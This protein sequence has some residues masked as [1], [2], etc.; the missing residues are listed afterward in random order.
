MHIKDKYI[1]VD[2]K[3]QELVEIIIQRLFNL[4]KTTDLK[5]SVLSVISF[6]GNTNF[7]KNGIFDLVESENVYSIKILFRSLIEHFLKFQYL[8]LRFLESQNDTIFTEFE[9]FSQYSDLLSYG[10]SLKNINHILNS[11]DADL[12]SFEILKEMFPE[13]KGQTNKW[14]K[15]KIEEYRIQNIIKYIN[16][17]I[18]KDNSYS[19]N[20]FILDLLPVYSELSSFVHGSSEA[21][22][23]MLKLSDPKL[24]MEDLNK[25][26]EFSLNIT[27]LISSSACLM[28]AK[29]DEG[30]IKYYNNFLSL[31]KH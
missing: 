4:L 15:D 3:Q 10:N 23:I 20:K 9:R 24:R 14:V 18:N 7:I 29:Q 6:I 17:R 12:S 28:F 2:D 13:L 26:V 31:L 22:K 1:T 25:S 30:L 8:L 16:D 19:S 5:R 27:L 11:K 21:N